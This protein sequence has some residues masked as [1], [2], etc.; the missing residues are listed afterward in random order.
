MVILDK[1]SRDPENLDTLLE[2]ASLA[3]QFVTEKAY[4]DIKALIG[5]VIQHSYF[6]ALLW[7]VGILQEE[8]EKDAHELDDFECFIGK[9]IP[10]F[11]DFMQALQ[12]G[13][14]VI[15]NDVEKVLDDN[16][17]VQSFFNILTYETGYANVHLISSENFDTKD[18]DYIQYKLA[19]TAAAPSY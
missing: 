3:R 18:N 7:I 15:K 10:N 9:S 8:F 11:N 6:D 4:D 12:I 14:Q 1:L 17:E 19:F 2:L 16:G 13:T 5:G